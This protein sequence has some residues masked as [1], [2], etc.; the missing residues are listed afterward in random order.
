MKFLKR[1][2]TAAAA[3]I[4]LAA[5]SFPVMCKMDDGGSV[6]Y[7]AALYSV[8]KH[9][10]FAPGFPLEDRQYIDGWRVEVLG[11]EVFDNF[12]RP[13]EECLPSGKDLH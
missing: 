11:M 2:K 8:T 13:F 10:C 4:L 1:W 7:R 6:E 3:F 5:L 12:S 9:H